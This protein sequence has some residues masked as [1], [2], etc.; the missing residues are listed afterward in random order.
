MRG[1]V[2]DVYSLAYVVGVSSLF[3]SV[4]MAGT[5]SFGAFLVL[6]I[7][8]LGSFCFSRNGTLL[9]RV[10]SEQDDQCVSVRLLFPNF[11]A[12]PGAEIK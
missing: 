10:R 8:D 1:V 5:V 2:E 7:E 6:L 3:S 4:G 12:S 9:G 11:P